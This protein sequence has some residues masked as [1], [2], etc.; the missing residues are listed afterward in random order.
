MVSTAN[1]TRISRLQSLS[2]KSNTLG[3]ATSKVT[4]KPVK[5]TTKDSFLK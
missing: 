2:S 1:K 4:V 3:Q 5:G